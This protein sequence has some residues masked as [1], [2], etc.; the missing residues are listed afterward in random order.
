MTTLRPLAIHGALECELDGACWSLSANGRRIVVDLPDLTTGFKLLRLGR[1]GGTMRTRLNAAKRLLD[2][3][4]Q[5]LEC[6]IS[7]R[8]V[9]LLGYE[10][11]HRTWLLTGLPALEV[12]FAGLFASFRKR[13]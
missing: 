11:G 4:T 9:L 8:R 13:H 6:R 7:G 12:S 1:P 5:Q 3:T 2:S 10:V